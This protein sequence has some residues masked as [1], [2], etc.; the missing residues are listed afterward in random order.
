MSDFI[1]SLEFAGLWSLDHELV[2][3]EITIW[4]ELNE[5]GV[6]LGNVEIV[7]E[8]KVAVVATLSNEL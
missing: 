3:L 6:T 1:W 4:Y 8:D 5:S 7:P 2:E